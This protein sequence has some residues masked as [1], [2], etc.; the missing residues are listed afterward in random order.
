LKA[1]VINRDW[2]KG[3]WICVAF[4]PT[5]RC[6]SRVALNAMLRV[7][8]GPYRHG[9]NHR[10]IPGQNQI[11][12]D[13]AE[14]GG[15]KRPIEGDVSKQSH[16]QIETSMGKVRKKLVGRI[17]LTLPSGPGALRQQIPPAATR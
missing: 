10:V 15:E 14:Q 5:R 1:H 9:N 2:Y 3:C 13:D 11:N 4:R 16:I 7:G 17:V 8:Q 6:W 12:D